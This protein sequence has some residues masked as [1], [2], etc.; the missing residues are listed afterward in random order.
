MPVEH[1]VPFLAP[2]N[3]VPIVFLDFETTGVM[4]GI[5]RAVEVGIARFELGCLVA[6]SGSLVN[7][8]MAIPE[9]SSLVH[10]IRDADV[11]NAPSVEDFFRLEP[12]QAILKGAQPAAYNAPFDR[13]FVPPWALADWTWPWLDTLT[14]VRNV[15]RAVSGAGRHRLEAACG[16]H[17]VRLASAHRAS[18]DARAAGELFHALMPA[19]FRT[20]PAIGNLLGWMRA[21]EAKEWHRFHAW[22]A[23]RP[24]KEAA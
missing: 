16:R 15:D 9:E 22:I 1:P 8:G 20:T 17:G 6:E 3:E 4:P 10:G 21:Q 23:N 19:A 18:D 2:W 5:D 11:A 7:P 12:V 24:R 14:L 13:W